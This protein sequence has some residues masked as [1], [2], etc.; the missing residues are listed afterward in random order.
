MEDNQ[1]SYKNRI[2][3]LRATSK[4]TQEAFGNLIGVSGSIV[5]K[6]EAGKNEPGPQSVNNIVE[7]LGVSREWLETGEG[8]MRSPGTNIPQDAPHENI[9]Q[10]DY[11]SVSQSLKAGGGYSAVIRRADTSE[12]LEENLNRWIDR[13]VD[14]EALM[15]MLNLGGGVYEQRVTEM[16]R[17][18]GDETVKIEFIARI[19]RVGKDTT[20]QKKEPPRPGGS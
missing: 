20:P 8:E 4:L 16:L 13:T 5:A 15:Q 9:G 6:W 14:P 18:V 1:Q 3:S 17:Q 10:K 19:V 11:T 2:K 7:K 12:G